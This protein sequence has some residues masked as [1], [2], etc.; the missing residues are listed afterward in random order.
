MPFKF[1]LKVPKLHYFSYVQK[2]DQ[3]GLNVLGIVPAR[4]RAAQLTL[5][6]KALCLSPKIPRDKVEQKKP[7]K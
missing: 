4:E 7:D 6:M 3:T 5:K 2:P 1:S